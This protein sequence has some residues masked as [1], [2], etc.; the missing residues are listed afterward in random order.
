MTG[1]V[2]PFRIPR[3]QKRE[4]WGTRGECQLQSKAPT[5]YKV[6][7]HLLPTEGTFSCSQ[8]PSR[9]RP[10]RYNSPRLIEV[11]IMAPTSIVITAALVLVGLG[12][13]FIAQKILD[14]WTQD[15]RR[16]PMIDKGRGNWSRYLRSVETELPPSVRQRVALCNRIGLLSMA[17]T[18]VVFI[19]DAVWHHH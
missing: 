18:P 8:V 13:G 2:E 19:L 7:P 3:H 17:L 10:A 15:A 1:E 11:H 9:R 4:M 6:M 16:A 5:E 14:Q 12:S